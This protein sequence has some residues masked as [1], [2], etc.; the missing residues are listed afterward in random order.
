VKIANKTY[1]LV[2]VGGEQA[3]VQMI[4]KQ[5][6]GTLRLEALAKEQPGGWEFEGGF[7]EFVQGNGNFAA[8]LALPR[9]ARFLADGIEKRDINLDF[10]QGTLTRQLVFSYGESV[11]VVLQLKQMKGDPETTSKFLAAKLAALAGGLRSYCRFIKVFE[12]TTGNWDSVATSWA[13]I[14]PAQ[15]MAVI[16]KS[17]VLKWSLTLNGT[18]TDIPGETFHFRLC[19]TDQQGR[20]M[21][22]PSESGYPK[23]LYQ[24]HSRLENLRFENIATVPQGEYKVQLQ[25]NP[26]GNYHWRGAYGPIILLLELD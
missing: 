25:A 14:T 4:W 13:D 15:G 2:C 18:W 1:E 5:E 9:V 7:D 3:T 10:A 8:F 21:F 19:A 26:H 17:G 20:K 6:A 16:P 22:W 23:Y 24:S 11:P 12:V